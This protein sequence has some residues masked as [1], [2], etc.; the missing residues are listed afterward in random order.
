MK[1]PD[2]FAKVASF[3][4]SFRF[5]AGFSKPLVSFDE[6]DLLF[7]AVVLHYNLLS[8]LSEINQFVEG[9]NVHGFIDY[10]RQYPPQAR[11][12]FL[13]NE[14]RLMAEKL[15]KLFQ[16]VFSSRGSNRR[17]NEEAV[18]LNF[19][20][21]LEDVE[22]GEIS[23]LIID[24]E[25]EELSEM[26]VTL[27][28]VLQFVTRSTSVPAIGFYPPPSI[29]FEHDTAGRKLHVHTCSNTLCLPVNDILLNYD[30]FKTEFTSCLAESP[31]FGNV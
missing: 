27:P 19:T 7:R 29:T 23:C 10:L 3:G 17:I 31:G 21:Y 25:T 22:S 24:L 1:D 13:Y 8:S 14:N 4:C 9:L 26:V 28:I 15:D 12:L 11:A 5:K 20:R 18:S 16:P 6:K 30:S 2:A